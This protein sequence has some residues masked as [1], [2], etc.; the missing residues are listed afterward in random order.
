M[1]STAAA[2]LVNKI[3]FE[4]V[5]NRFSTAVPTWRKKQLELR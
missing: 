4:G 3:V 5:L 1:A 2:M